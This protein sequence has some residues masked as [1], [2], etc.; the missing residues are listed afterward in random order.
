MLATSRPRRG[1][2]GIARA[3]TRAGVL[4]ILSALILLVGQFAAFAGESDKEK[5]A[6]HRSIPGLRP[7]ATPLPPGGP[8]LPVTLHRGL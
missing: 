2:L 8:P 3:S 7:G 1:S 6:A 4:A 5:P